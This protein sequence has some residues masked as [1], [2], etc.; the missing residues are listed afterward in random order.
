MNIVVFLFLDYVAWHYHHHQRE[1][2]F[3]EASEIGAVARFR[4]RLSISASSV[5]TRCVAS[6]MYFS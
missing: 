6:S 2:V 3:G 4:W 1:D 5:K